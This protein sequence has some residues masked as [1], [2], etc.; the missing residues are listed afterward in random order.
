MLN[1][2]FSSTSLRF[3]FFILTN[4]AGK[5]AITYFSGEY[6]CTFSEASNSA[7]ECLQQMKEAD[8]QLMR[9]KKSVDRNHMKELACQHFSPSSRLC[10]DINLDT[11]VFNME[12]P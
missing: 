11:Q 7:S 2:P 4:P 9:T 12:L 3:Y 5:V 6:D 1:F 8:N 10:E